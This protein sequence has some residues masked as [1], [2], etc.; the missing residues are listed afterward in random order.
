MDSTP[1]DGPQHVRAL[2]RANHV[3]SARA[4]AKRRIAS[5]ELTAA[6]V[7]LAHQWEFDTMPITEI[8]ISQRQWGRGRCH[9]FLLRLTLREDKE[10]GSMTQRQRTAA[11][12]LL[13]DRSRSA[14]Y[15]CTALGSAGCGPSSRPVSFLAVSSSRR[16][17]LAT[18]R[19][20][21]S[22]AR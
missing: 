12:A 10:I 18:E 17:S 13:T 20:K 5:G 15:S 8:L 6:E 4:T 3:R 21:P 9:Q 2:E 22:N 19:V 11:A 1:G 7:I 16:A 14:G